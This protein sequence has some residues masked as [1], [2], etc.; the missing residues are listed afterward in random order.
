MIGQGE[1]LVSPAAM[2]VVAASIGAG[3]RVS[4]HLV[5]T[6]APGASDY[7]AEPSA[8]IPAEAEALREMMRLTVT[9]GTAGTLAGYGAE[10]GAKTGTAEYG[11]GQSPGTHAWMIAVD[12]ARDLALAT[13]VEGGASG[14]ETAGPLV[15]AFLDQYSVSQPE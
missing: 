7:G 10:L 8:L 1:V 14:G 13:L 9:S 6:P 3:S 12:P 11:S 5:S 2:A 4:P 15:A